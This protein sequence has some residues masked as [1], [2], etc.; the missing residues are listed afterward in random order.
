MFRTYALITCRSFDYAG[1]LRIVPCRWFVQRA[2]ATHLLLDVHMFRSNCWVSCTEDGFGF[3]AIVIWSEDMQVIL[4][5]S[6]FS[7]AFAERLLRAQRVPSCLRSGQ[8]AL[9][10]QLTANP[11]WKRTWVPSLDELR[12]LKDFDS[13]PKR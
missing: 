7:S 10:R 13:V 5:G 3:L 8:A 9:L 11:P 1:V 2:D 12:L 6:G 4:S